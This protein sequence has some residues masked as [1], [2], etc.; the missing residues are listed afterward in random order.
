M[1][2]LHPRL[3]QDSITIG[4]FPL[5]RLLLMDDAQYPWFILVPMRE[6][7]SEI[8]QLSAQDRAVLSEESATLSTAMSSAFK[9][10]KMNIASLGNIVP[11]LHIHHIARF[12]SD[13]TWPD[14][15]WGR[16][17]P[18]P[19][20]PGMVAARIGYLRA[21]LADKVQWDVPPA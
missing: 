3:A 17:L 7:I 13:P 4:H 12:T 16:K 14:P 6:E 11:Q 5:C 1:F 10:D 15:V 19:Y 8:H 2:T 21:A 9:A 20:T 18:E